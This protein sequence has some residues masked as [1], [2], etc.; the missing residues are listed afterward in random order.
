MDQLLRLAA[1]FTNYCD[2]CARTWLTD[3]AC[4]DFWSAADI[5][6]TVALITPFAIWI[7]RETRTARLIRE[8]QAWLDAR[9][10]I[11]DAETIE[12]LSWRGDTVHELVASE[13][14]IAKAIRERTRSNISPYNKTGTPPPDTA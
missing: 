8:H 10:A 9:A 2:H 14:E 12:A 7:Y 13:E 11:A 4:V 5:A 6:I 3:P 1:R